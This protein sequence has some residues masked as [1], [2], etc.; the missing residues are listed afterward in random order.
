M[1][2]RPR[3]LHARDL[4]A[5]N[6][7]ADAERS[8][9]SRLIRTRVSAPACVVSAT[10]VFGGATLAADV[11]DP[12][13]DA[14]RTRADV[15]ARIAPS[16]VAIFGPQGGG[17]GSGVLI[18]PDGY[19]VTNYHVTSGSGDWMKCGLA[20]GKL[21]DAVIVGTDPT[22]D[23]ALVRLLGRDDFPAATLGDSDAVNVG[24]WVLAL[25]NP[26][27][28]AKADFQPTVTYG[29]V[30]GTHRYQE[31]AG[32]FLEYTDCLQVDASINPGN[33]GGP[34]FNAAGELVGINGRISI[35]RGRVNSGA[36]Y[37]ISIN[38]VK[39]FLGHLRSGRIVDHGTLGATVRTNFDGAV[40]VT[41]VLD[42]SD[43]HRRGLREGDE[44]VEFA[45]RP[46]RS[47][48]Q[49]KNVLGIYPAGWTLPLTYRRDGETTE[50]RVRLA[51]LNRRSDL[52]ATDGGQE[53]PLAKPPPPPPEDVAKLIEKRPGFSNAHANEVETGRVLD[54][55]QRPAPA[56]ELRGPWRLTG[57]DPDGTAFELTLA[58]NV[59][60]LELGRNVSVQRLAPDEPPVDEPP[61]SGG[62]LFALHHWRLLTGGR[63]DGFAEFYYVG[64]EPLDGVGE[65]VDVL[66]AGDRGAVT[67]FYVRDDGRLAG[68]DT[69]L[70]PAAHYAAVR[71]GEPRDVDGLTLPA[72]IVASLGPD[73][74]RTLRVDTARVGTTEETP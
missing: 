7:S 74:F 20:D 43:A 54:A 63:T 39:H 64:R 30:S 15:V 60:G 23:V 41:A 40:E 10:L 11:P 36:G 72:E 48:N 3:D 17:G 46:V 2:Q 45:G 33:S 70:D 32:T 38:Q 12:V 31:P 47:T 73:P 21:Y 14:Q 50:I 51:P 8:R 49:F 53:N 52:L 55:L 28:L 22:G 37:A 44:V 66:H 71:F 18:S 6:G 57:T 26:F 67:R 27:L 56:D 35:K 13:L 5:T 62:L 4:A 61:G 59:A 69:R 58:D 42:S 24:D 16:V 19:A 1:H 9:W 68:L 65:T 25:G 34:L 29:V